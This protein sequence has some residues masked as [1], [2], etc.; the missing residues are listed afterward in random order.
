MKAFLFTIYLLGVLFSTK[1]VSQ[2]SYC[3]APATAYYGG[4]N[5]F[6][7]VSGDFNNDGIIDLASTHE[8]GSSQSGIM[9][10]YG[11]GNGT[12]G[13]STNYSN[14][15]V[16]ARSIVSA[17][18]NNDGISDIAAPNGNYS[19]SVF[20][21]T[22]TGTLSPMINIAGGFAAV[23]G[24]TA[25]DFNNDNKIDIALTNSGSTG[26]AVLLGL[27][28][29]SFSAQS[30]FSFGYQSSGIVCADFNGDGNIDLATSND[31]YNGSIDVSLGNGA[32]GFANSVASYSVDP[33]PQSLCIKD[34]NGDG[35]NDLAVISGY[36]GVVSVFLSSSSGLFLPKVD[37]PIS[38][39][40][41]QPTL[42]SIVSNDFDGDNILDLAVNLFGGGFQICLGTGTGTFGTPSSVITSTLSND[43]H[44]A[45]TDDF[46]GDTKP[47]I[48]IAGGNSSNVL[49]FLHCVPLPIAT[50]NTII[51]CSCFGLC[52]GNTIISITGG[53]SPYTVNVSNGVTYTNTTGSFTI[54]NLCSGAYSFT[55]TD[56]LSSVASN[57][58]SISQPTAL[59]LI[60]S[61]SSYTVCADSC[62]TMQVSASGGTP[63]Y[64]YYWSV[65]T[66][67][68]YSN[69]ICPP[70]NPGIQSAYINDANNCS[71]SQTM[72]INVDTTCHYDYVWPGDANRD[73]TV[74]N[75]DL[76]ELGLH[77][78]QSGPPRASISNLWQSYPANN[79]VGT[80]TNGWNLKHSDCNGDGIINASDTLAIYN[81]YNNAAFYKQNYQSNT[82][83]ELT[84]VP[85][86]P[87]VLKGQ[88]GTSSIYFGDSTNQISSVNGIAYTVYF[89]NY[90]LVVD[91]IFIVYENSFIDVT[92][93][94]L[95]FQKLEFLNG[96]I[97]TATTHTNN[98][99][100]NG[101]GKIATLHYKIRD[102]L[103]TN[104][105]LYILLSTV[106]KSNNLGVIAPLSGGW[107]LVDIVGATVG[108]KEISDNI[109]SISPNPTNGSLNI[110]S[111]TELQKIEVVAIT[112][113]VMMSEIPT[114][115]SHTLNLENFANGIYFVNLY[116]N[117]RIVKREKVVVNK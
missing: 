87:Q 79:W 116:Q 34:F 110:N 19:I 1:I 115:N 94:N 88:W 14:G 86:Q 107:A 44:K 84:L 89:D 64:T 66:S 70:S 100:S 68:T 11:I 4:P 95:K 9:V 92:R 37:Y 47:D 112:G 35:K 49:V 8:S 16:N 33:R 15:G 113:Q 26:V 75:I 85:D 27:G 99:N 50:S 97:Y 18:F 43:T 83:P 93:S 42:S 57:F 71:A 6:N 45:C 39:G 13:T 25:G 55:V 63:P 59:F 17:D 62:V 36:S 78:T 2:S 56:D 20:L 104:E 101:N 96:L 106:N 76:L 114:G 3:F 51:N 31:Y 21:G 38:S 61:Q 109:I 54:S 28:T 40:S 24:I 69:T 117:N 102:D 29:G 81:N 72:A 22:N 65:A 48:A 111:K 46:D 105:Q 53:I 91:S 5:T 12:F 108:L 67:T 80:V 52:D 74:N 30:I 98:I 60:A 77:Y 73:G 90:T 58:F 41:T 7:V 103:T 32:G 23:N 10:M 82:G